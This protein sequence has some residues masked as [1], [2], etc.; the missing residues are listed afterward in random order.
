[1]N[2]WLLTVSIV[3]CYGRAFAGDTYVLAVKESG[4]I[5]ASSEVPVVVDGD[6]VKCGSVTLRGVK[7]GAYS[8]VTT[9]DVVT[10]KK[11]VAQLANSKPV[12]P[13]DMKTEVASQDDRT[14][15]VVGVFQKWHN[16]LCDAVGKPELKKTDADVV[17]AVKTVADEQAAAKKGNPK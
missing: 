3:L 8:I 4:K 1:M 16:D 12:D 11:N 14:S 6:V 5:L 10:G 9:T 7:A 17:A 13:V 15:A 2:R